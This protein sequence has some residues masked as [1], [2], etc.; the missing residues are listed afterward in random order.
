V[1]FTFLSLCATHINGEIHIC[2]GTTNYHNGPQRG[3]N[4]LQGTEGLHTEIE[5]NCV[6]DDVNNVNKMPF[7]VTKY[8]GYD[9]DI[10]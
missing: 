8:C 4:G 1:I 2:I 6:N 3:H 5:Q 10:A 7:T 9:P